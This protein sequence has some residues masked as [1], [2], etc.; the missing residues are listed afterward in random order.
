MS[1]TARACGRVNLLGEHTDYTGGLVLPA[2]IP[3]G[4]TVHADRGEDGLI[5]ILSSSFPEGVRLRAGSSPP[6]PGSLSW[7]NYVLGVLSELWPR[8]DFRRGF[9]LRVESDLPMGAGLASSAALAV[10]SA[11]AL[12]QLFGC[13]SGAL[14]LAQ[15]CQRAEQRYAGVRCGL[16]DQAAASLLAPGEA[17]F[18]DC[19]TLRWKVLALPSLALA[20]L[21]SGVRHAL[22]ESGYNE[23]VEECVELRRRLGGLASLGELSPEDLSRLKRGLPGT[24]AKRLEHVVRENAR[25][26]G[27]VAC[28][29]AGDL[30]GFGR[31]MLESHAS[32]RDLYEVSCP[33]L[34][35]LV[36]QAGPLVFGA[37]MTGAGFGGAVVAILPVEGAE[38]MQARF[39]EAR[40][41]RF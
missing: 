25:V 41:F 40:V 5:E 7:A 13:G 27:G 9:R 16:M 10:A 11:K 37:K 1:V 8:A 30:A 14:P 17:L 29:E 15:A 6:P 2:A 19:R 35:A 3:W 20:V 12:D 23:R 28:L 34:D 33:E 21:P 18:L 32:L 36:D 39:P 22:A 24:L 38:V 4:V 26:R 31:L